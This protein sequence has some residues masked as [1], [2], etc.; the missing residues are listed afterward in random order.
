MLL[1]VGDKKKRERMDSK[2]KE[3]GK[4]NNNNPSFFLSDKAID[5]CAAESA[6]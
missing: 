1:E 2:L 4:K 5:V 3:R 6:V